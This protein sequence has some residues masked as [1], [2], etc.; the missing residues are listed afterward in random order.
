MRTPLWPSRRA[1]V[2]C[3]VLLGRSVTPAEAQTTPAAAATGPCPADTT[4][5]SRICQ[6]GAD[7]LTTFL[8]IEG[9]L[10]DGGNPVP[11][12]AGAI[13][14]FGHARLA[15]RVGFASLTAPK[16]S[17]DGSSDTVLADKRLLVP[18]PRVDLDV[19]LFSKKLP[20]GTVAMDLLGS[21]VLLPTGSTTRIGIDENARKIGPLAL[22]LGFGFRAALIMKAPKP[23]ASLSVMKR[24]MPV[25]RFGDL[26]KGDKLSAATSLSAINV[27]LIFGGQAK[28]L[29][30]AGGLGVDMYKGAGTVSYADSAGVDTTVTTALSTMRIMTLL[31]LGYDLGPATLWVEGGFQVGKKTELVTVFQRN[32]PSAG[33]FYG[34]AGLAL[35]F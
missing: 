25:I 17:Y 21:A 3:L 35:R 4:T 15:A 14:R 9:L 34:G 1:V 16:T 24:D 20:L 5:S 33:R 23:T 31:N 19:G 28:S 13:G 8:P 7:L 26:A 11:G 18:L 27:R 10:V 30:I 2:V 12:T 22:G 6:A 29:S 32:D